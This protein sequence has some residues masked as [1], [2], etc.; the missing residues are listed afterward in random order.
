MSE[1]SFPR[2]SPKEYFDGDV[3]FSVELN[4][5]LAQRVN[6]SLTLPVFY[7]HHD[8]NFSIRL[9]KSE[10]DYIDLLK[11]VKI[12]G[13]QYIENLNYYWVDYIP[14]E[15]EKHPLDL[16]FDLV[17]VPGVKPDM[18]GMLSSGKLYWRF[19][20]IREA[21]ESVN[22]TIDKGGLSEGSAR[23][24]LIVDYLGTPIGDLDYMKGLHM[25]RN[26]SRCV[27]VQE[28]STET[29]GKYPQ[30]NTPFHA[31]WKLP[32]RND[33]PVREIRFT[34]EKMESSDLV[35]IRREFRREDIMIYDEE[36]RSDA[37]RLFLGN[38]HGEGV[39]PFFMYSDNTPGFLGQ[40][41]IVDASSVKQVI[42]SIRRANE[43]YGGKMRFVLSEAVRLT[44]EPIF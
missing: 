7:S 22:I 26:L 3:V 9:S 39:S 19:K 37:P 8:R 40:T 29:A 1:I 24:S 17:D 2:G 30:Y 4:S 35:R 20:Y 32:A 33:E 31:E 16:L 43:H 10:S 23:S 36:Y 21:E 27:V 15:A 6:P 42:A 14:T 5:P 12:G 25:F 11:F 44:P 28:N 13:A 18:F 38:S 41:W 34:P